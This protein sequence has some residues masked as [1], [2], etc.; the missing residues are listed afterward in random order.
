MMGLLKTFKVLHKQDGTEN[1]KIIQKEREYRES[2]RNYG[3]VMVC[4]VCHWSQQV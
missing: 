2:L 1:L 4:N 3:K